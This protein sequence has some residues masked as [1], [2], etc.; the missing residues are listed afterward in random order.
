MSFAARPELAADRGAVRVACRSDGLARPPA[1]LVRAAAERGARLGWGSLTTAEVTELAELTGPPGAG[2]TAQPG[3]R[4]A[5]R[6]H[7]RHPAVRPGAAP[8]PARPDAARTGRDL[9]GAAVAARA[10]RVPADGVHRGRGIPRGGRGGA[11]RR[12]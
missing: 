8:R 4:A 6:A 9:A 1:G 2:A 12:L 7:R 10:G 3:R 11:R 5:A